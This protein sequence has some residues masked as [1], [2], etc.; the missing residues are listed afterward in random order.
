M[1][2]PINTPFVAALLTIVGYSINDTIVIFDRIR[3][4]IKTGG[5]RG[6]SFIDL[7]NGSI[8]QTISRT[9]I[10]SLTTLMVVTTLFILGSD[11]IKDFALAL[12]IGVISGTYSTLY[13][14]SPVLIWWNKKW[15]ITRK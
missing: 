1:A 10:T 6:K 15:P 9:V 8:N 4:N 3:E 5:T 14:A 12:M 7:I 13:I 2:A 11:A